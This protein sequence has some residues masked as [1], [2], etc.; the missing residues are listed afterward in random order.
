MLPVAWKRPR[1]WFIHTDSSSSVRAVATARLGCAHMLFTEHAHSVRMHILCHI[2]TP[3][4]DGFRLAS[5][6]HAYAVVSLCVHAY[7]SMKKVWRIW[8]SGLVS[9][10]N[11]FLRCSML[12]R[13][14]PK[15]VSIPNDYSEILM[16]TSETW[17]IKTP[18]M[19][20]DAHML[21]TIRMLK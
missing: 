4:Y 18:W 9:A 7:I 20:G 12:E 21:C 15:L 3:V 1:A 11:M 16:Y 6:C 2:G 8:A 13:S 5:I 14:M 19:P 10:L 17:S